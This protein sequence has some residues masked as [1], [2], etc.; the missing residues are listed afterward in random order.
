MIVGTVGGNPVKDVC[1]YYR[2]VTTSSDGVS[3][4]SKWKIMSGST[5]ADVPN[6]VIVSENTKVKLN[7]SCYY[8]VING[9]CYVTLWGVI[10]TEAGKHVVNSSMPKTR[11]T[12]KGVCTYGSNGSYGYGGS[13]YIYYDGNGNNKLYIEAKSAESLYG[14]F[15]YPVAE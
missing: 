1:I 6:T 14:S 11:L 4:F 8:T 12:M 13:A 9:V 2:G 5:V 15:S 3:A 7:S 10:C